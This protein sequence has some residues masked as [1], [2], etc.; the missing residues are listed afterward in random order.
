MLTW[1]VL[2]N[3]KTHPLI[4]PYKEVRKTYLIL[5]RIFSAISKKSSFSS[6]VLC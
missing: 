2:L 3:F 5:E 6:G 1:R 4:P